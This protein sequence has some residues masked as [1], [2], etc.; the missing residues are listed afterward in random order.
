MTKKTLI[1]GI[2]LVGLGL[3]SIVEG[4]RLATRLRQPGFYDVVGPDRYA[5]G[6]GFLLVVTG[7]I[8]VFSQVKEKPAIK[9]PTVDKEGE[10][11][12]TLVKVVGTVGVLALYAFLM[13]IIGYFLASTVFFVLV[14]KIL[15]AKS[16]LFNIIYSVAVTGICQ[17][18]F[19]NC[20]GVILPQ[21]YININIPV[22]RF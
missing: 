14:S 2:I 4:I 8:Y 15:G 10:D 9:E 21:G 11:K 16:W 6:I 7:A 19:G 17:L 18:I 12:E 13:P 20:L 22:P 1:E 5:I 3:M